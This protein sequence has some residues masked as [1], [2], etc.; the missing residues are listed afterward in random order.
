VGEVRRGIQELKAG[1]ETRRLSDTRRRVI[2]ATID[3]IIR[4]MTVPEFRE[5]LDKRMRGVPG[6]MK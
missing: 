4:R 1:V 2:L 5:M 3:E 6:E